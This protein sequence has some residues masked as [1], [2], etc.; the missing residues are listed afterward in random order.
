[1]ISNRHTMASPLSALSNI[2]S[3]GIGA[4]ESTYAERGATFPSLNELFQ[5]GPLD[6]DAKLM[7]II[8]YV[9]SAA[10]Q[11]IALITPPPSTILESSFAVSDHMCSVANSLLILILITQVPSS[12]EPWCSC[13]SKYT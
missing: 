12:G 9:V 3:T 10:S 5:P 13:T 4:I 8:D 11:L 1:M 7:E 2:I 6:G